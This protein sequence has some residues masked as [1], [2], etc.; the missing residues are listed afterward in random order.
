MQKYYDEASKW[1][2]LKEIPGEQ[3]NK[4][5][6]EMFFRVGHGWVKDDETPWCAAFVGSV[7]GAS[8]G[9]STRALNARSYLEWGEAVDVS[10]AQRG[11]VVVLWRKDKD[12]PYGHVGFFD[13]ISGGKIYLLGGN[14]NNQVSIAHYPLDRLL[15]IRRE[16]QPRTSPIQSKT[17]RATAVQIGGSAAGALTAIAALDGTAQIAALGFASVIIIAAL[18]ILRERLLKWVAGDK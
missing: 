12:G 13:R 11:D 15:S 8:G 9:K 1:I 5:I 16:K 7:I 18:F 17:V 10:D 2:G 3:H 4:K 14:Q 6:A